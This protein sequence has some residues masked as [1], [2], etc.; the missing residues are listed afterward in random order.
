MRSMVILWRS[1]VGPGLLH[2]DGTGD[3]ATENDRHQTDGDR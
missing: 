3:A 1:G 2:R